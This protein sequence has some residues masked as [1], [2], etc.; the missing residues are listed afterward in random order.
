M[1]S[2]RIFVF[3]LVW[4]GFS[5]SALLRA[6]SNPPFKNPS[7]D[8]NCY[9]PQIGVPG[10]IDTIYGNA[11][12]TVGN[13]IYGSGLGAYIHNLGSKPDGSP[14][15]MLIGNDNPVFEQA[16]TGSS[17]NL[18]NLHAIAQNIHADPSALRF[19]HFH[20]QTHLD[21]F[22]DVNWIIY[23][24]DDNGNYDSAHH[25]QLES[26]IYGSYGIGKTPIWVNSYIARLTK[27]SIDDIVVGFFTSDSIRTKD[28]LYLALFEG[29]S[30]YN[31]PIAYEDTS[32]TLPPPYLNDDHVTR[33]G[34]FRG[35]GRDDLLVADYYNNLFF[36]KNDPPFSLDK[37]VHAILYDTLMSKPID[38]DTTV[39]GYFIDN[40][41]IMQG[42]PQ[43]SG[44][45]YFDWVVMIPTRGIGNAIFFFRGG[46]NFGSHRIT[47]DS[48]AYVIT[49]PQLGE[50]SWP[51]LLSD[52]GDLTGTGNHVLYVAA[53]DG[54]VAY[55]NYYVTGQALDNKIDIY[56]SFP[57][58]AGGDTLT[59]NG[60][61]LE[62]I[63]MGLNYTS[64][65]DLSN[66]LREVGSMWVMYGSKQIP[67]HLNPQFADVKGIPQ[68]N[69]AGIM[70][71]PNP[72]NQW[73]VATIVWPESE[74]G[75]YS[76]Y[77]MLGRRVEHGPIRLL[78][79]A[80]QQRIYFSGMPQGVYIYTIEGAHGSASAR[81]VKLGSASGSSGTSQPSIIQQM[82]QTRDAGTNS[83]PQSSE[84]P[85]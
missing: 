32:I 79:G 48:A 43:K 29:E 18:H 47:T 73:S 62:D 85:R 35:I 52:A 21:I 80:E 72:A 57:A 74:E 12:D 81:F 3:L 50:S 83:F 53:D 14:G 70:L 16:P 36:Y 84:L 51:D 75:E 39:P 42:L 22:D 77:D 65:N 66:G 38:L 41:L 33:Q 28:S 56:N 1:E 31:H 25:T 68:E 19:G 46:P 15:N 49:A 6:Q 23:W 7:L 27:D 71:S 44:D 63:L 69:G 37:L 40:T 34:D 58:G 55:Q 76:I 59:A 9:F 10:E 11:T 20:D 5:S 26:N 61:S 60:D 78:G 8:S 13:F 54:A 67:V 45:N 64:P 24:A 17:F 2:L 4:A 82:K 30:L